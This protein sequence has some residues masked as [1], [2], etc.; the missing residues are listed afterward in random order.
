M[1][2]SN[3][4]YLLI[5]VYIGGRCEKK[6]KRQELRTTVQILKDSLIRSLSREV[7]KQLRSGKLTLIE[8]LE[9]NIK[10]SEKYAEHCEHKYWE[11]LRKVQDKYGM[12]WDKD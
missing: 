1:S 5:L 7:E 12:R 10:K 3:M 6:A 8:Y 11:L 9:R 4:K 2:R